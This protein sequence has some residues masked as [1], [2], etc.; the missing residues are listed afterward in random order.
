MPV[1]KMY[2][3]RSYHRTQ[4]IGLCKPLRGTVHLVANAE[5]FA[6]SDVVLHC[7]LVSDALAGKLL[8]KA[9]FRKLKFQRQ[10]QE[11]GEEDKRGGL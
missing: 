4:V 1:K 10:I 5:I 3:F 8:E 2:G 9:S 11:L 6:K 7:V